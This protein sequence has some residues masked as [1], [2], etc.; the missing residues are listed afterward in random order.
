[1]SVLE[2]ESCQLTKHHRLPSVPRVNK[3]ASS[4]FE[5]VHSDI[6]GLCSITSKLGVRYFVTFMDDYS[7]VIWLYLV[8]N[9]S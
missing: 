5:L 7:R 9:H 2:C 3:R 4:L 1:M 6:W 8:K